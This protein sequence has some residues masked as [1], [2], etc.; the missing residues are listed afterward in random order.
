MKSLRR[1]AEMQLKKVAWE[2]LCCDQLLKPFSIEISKL[3]Q[4]SKSRGQCTRVTGSSKQIRGHKQF[5]TNAAHL[6][7][8]LD[9]KRGKAL[10]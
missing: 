1:L 9:C 3:A 6:T 7:P 8:E 2:G 5:T 4:G 10:E